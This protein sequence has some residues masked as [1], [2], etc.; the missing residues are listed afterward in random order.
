MS[1]L[2]LAR[3]RSVSIMVLSLVCA[4]MSIPMASSFVDRVQANGVM[5][6]SHQ[7]V[8]LATAYQVALNAAKGWDPSS[9]LVNVVS[10]QQQDV[11]LEESIEFGNLEQVVWSFAFASRSTGTRLYLDIKGTEVV[12]QM[13]DPILAHLSRNDLQL[14][15]ISDEASIFTPFEIAQVAS[16]EYKEPALAAGLQ[17]DQEW[18]FG[19]LYRLIKENGKPYMTVMALNAHGQLARVIFDPVSGQELGAIHQEMQ[20]VGRPNDK[21]IVRSIWLNGMD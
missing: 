2:R 14:A 13:E 3:V 7:G 6:P 8:P 15:L 16:H 21:P 18:P 17:L 20:L 5:Q 1:Y 10:V 9:T 12:R 19:V 11:T 4:L